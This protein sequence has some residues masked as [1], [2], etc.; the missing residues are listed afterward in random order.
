MFGFESGRGCSDCDCGDASISLDCDVVT[1]Q[2]QCQAGVA[3][4]RCDQCQQGYWKYR[5]HGCQSEYWR[6]F[7]A[8]TRL[9]WMTRTLDKIIPKK[10]YNNL[11]EF[12]LNQL[13]CF[14]IMIL[15][16]WKFR[17]IHIYLLKITIYIYFSLPGFCLQTIVIYI[18]Y[19]ASD[20]TIGFCRMELFLHC[21]SICFSCVNTDIT[22]PTEKW[23]HFASFCTM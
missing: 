12:T 22:A 13:S 6:G 21:T 19:P 8:S 17:F 5:P 14:E 7:S 18:R 10:K 4:R 16:I 1:G 3:G 15:L 20:C 23:Y 11:H 2:C 9:C